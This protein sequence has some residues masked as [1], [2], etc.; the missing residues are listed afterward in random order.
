[1]EE[2]VIVAP[3]KWLI[4]L[5]LTNKSMWIF[6]SYLIPLLHVKSSK[7]AQLQEVFN[8]L[9]VDYCFASYQINDIVKY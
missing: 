3:V 7:P 2:A 4:I 8:H 9:Y 6:T 5:S 1:M